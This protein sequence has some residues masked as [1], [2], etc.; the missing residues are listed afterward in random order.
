MVSTGQRLGE[1]GRERAEGW[2]WRWQKVGGRGAVEGRTLKV[3]DV[4]SIVEMKFVEKRYL[5][6]QSGGESL[7]LQ[8]QVPKPLQCPPP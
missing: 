7:M 5:Y 6:G 4:I 1:H 2:T 8:I 3:E